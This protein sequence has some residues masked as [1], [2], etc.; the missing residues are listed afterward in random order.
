MEL[1]FYLAAYPL[2]RLKLWKEL[3]DYISP[4]VLEQLEVTST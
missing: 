1:E 3:S 4:Q 2:E